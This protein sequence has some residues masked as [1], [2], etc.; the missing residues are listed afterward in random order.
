M[1]LRNA[2]L[3][4]YVQE[5]IGIS[6]LAQCDNVPL[7]GFGSN[8]IMRRAEEPVKYTFTISNDFCS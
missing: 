4:D 5:F 8:R 7:R 3:M 1:L 2:A 6:H